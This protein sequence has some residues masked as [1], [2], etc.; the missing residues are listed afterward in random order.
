[1]VN[2]TM[3]LVNK[4]VYAIEFVEKYYLQEF[5]EKLIIDRIFSNE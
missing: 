1:M 3:T 4:V 2:C 5:Y